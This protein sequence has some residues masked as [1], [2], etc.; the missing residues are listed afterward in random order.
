MPFSGGY[1]LV[2]HAKASA[3]SLV[4]CTAAHS[5]PKYFAGIVIVSHLAEAEL[6]VDVA[7]SIPENQDGCLVD[8]YC[9]LL[10]SWFPGLWIRGHVFV[11][12]VVVSSRKCVVNICLKEKQ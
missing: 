4:R 1:E 10:S 8:F 12:I 11:V 9:K 2:S 6:A 7:V 3:A 5:G